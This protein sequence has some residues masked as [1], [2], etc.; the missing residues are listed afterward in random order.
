M[1]TPQEG[2]ELARN[3]RSPSAALS[4]QDVFASEQHFIANRRRAAGFREHDMPGEKDAQ[5][6]PD[7]SNRCQHTT[8]GLALSGGGIRSA[9]IGLG[10]IQVL[11]KY[12]LFRYV[13]YLSAISGGSYTGALI[14]SS[15]YRATGDTAGRRV[16]GDT[17][18]DVDLIDQTIQPAR[19]R[20]LMNDGRYLM[21]PLEWANR[22]LSGWLSL[23]LVAGSALLAI[24]ALV[25]FLWRSMDFYTV[26]HYLSELGLASDMSSALV[27][28]CV[29]FGLWIIGWGFSYFRD[30]ASARGRW[31]KKILVAIILCA[32][33]TVAGLIGNGDIEFSSG[34]QGTASFLK[35]PLIVSI[36]GGLIPTLFR[37]QLF[38]S[39]L[40]ESSFIEKLIYRYT[41]LAVVLG[42]PMLLIGYFARE[43]VSGFSASRDG[44]LLWG[45]VKDFPALYS[46]FEQPAV[47]KAIAVPDVTSLLDEIRLL[48]LAQSEI[49]ARIRG[50]NR[51]RSPPRPPAVFTSIGGDDVED[52]TEVLTTNGEPL[53]S[54]SPSVLPV[55]ATDGRVD[56]TE[57]TPYEPAVTNPAT[58]FDWI[59]WNYN[60][61]IHRGGVL[62]GHLFGR[63]SDDPLALAILAQKRLEDRESKLLKVFNEYFLVDRRFPSEVLQK[64][65]VD[66][67]NLSQPPGST[68][69]DERK[70]YIERTV[71][72]K[73]SNLSADEVLEFNRT[74]LEAA[75]PELIRTRSDIRRTV[76]IHP[77]Q[78]HRFLM[79][80]L[81]AG[82]FVVSAYIINPNTT[83]IQRYYQERLAGAYLGGSDEAHNMRL[84]DLAPRLG[85]GPLL[86]L[87]G[88]ANYRF[89]PANKDKN[90]DPVSRQQPIESTDRIGRFEFSPLFCGSKDLDYALTDVY[91]NGS[92][93]LADAVAI[94][95]AALNPL[96]FERWE[97]L[98][99]VGLLNLRL[100]QWMPNP[101]GGAISLKPTF[102]ALMR[103]IFCL[104][105]RR[106]TAVTER[107]HVLLTD[108]GH[109]DNTGLQALLERRCKV[110]IVCDG[111][112]DANYEF[113]SFATVV[114][115]M[116]GQEGITFHEIGTSKELDL[117]RCSA[118]FKNK[119]AHFFCCEVKYPLRA[120]STSCTGLL[121]YFKSSL[122]SDEPPFVWHHAA[123]NETFPHDST[124][125][126]SFSPAQFCA[127]LG[128]GQ[129][130]VESTVEG[131]RHA[132]KDV[133]ASREFTLR[134][135]AEL[136]LSHVE[137]TRRKQFLDRLLATEPVGVTAYESAASRFNETIRTR[138][139]EKLPDAMAQ[140][141]ECLAARVDL[142]PYGVI[143][144]LLAGAV[145]V[146]DD[147]PHP[148]AERALQEAAIQ[149][150]KVLAG[151]C[152]SDDKSRTAQKMAC[153]IRAR[154]QQPGQYRS[155]RPILREA[156]DGYTDNLI[157]HLIRD[158][159]IAQDG[160]IVEVMGELGERLVKS[161]VKKS[162]QL[163]RILSEKRFSS[164]TE[165]RDCADRL[166]ALLDDDGAPNERR[167]PKP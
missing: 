62:L 92:L 126:Q 57:M 55:P 146:L 120:A 116:K 99:I 107:R 109:F 154:F 139:W 111:T 145:I 65:K 25:A 163:R 151:A 1:A 6:P 39:G 41:A 24:S 153:E 161:R 101:G 79:F 48:R 96:Y 135:F 67:L 150:S 83:S 59:S 98:V 11:R 47:E 130:F 136:F 95:G 165:I 152:E 141:R 81:F 54:N 82:I 76:V 31:A 61:I 115:R 108:G 110:V 49:Q 74:F 5:S 71:A 7:Q 18:L 160:F 28:L 164:V 124:V 63:D 8:V 75:H 142:P 9:S 68:F 70:A 147:D 137:E 144:D 125:N 36:F 38:R 149:F 94:S 51:W 12:G 85:S 158:G 118:Q 77:D 15:Y 89:R 72:N 84:T 90:P 43:D 93:R 58:L 30:G 16:D 3:C 100:G 69:T 53:L 127:Y 2:E 129:H 86:L 33:A 133:G 105:Q 102:A 122:S 45:D 14:A 162:S 87:G 35:I 119:E 112:Q 88:A 166:F 131:Q 10:F 4:F 44:R 80:L 56:A 143:L 157:E 34:V 148:N 66:K 140:L 113:D 97:M 22:F 42:I 106:V 156:G 132:V 91:Y 32:I 73:L 29:L 155:V 134:D 13:D 78:L 37:K 103:D 50:S 121:V 114:G 17:Q 23:L 117:G 138:Q 104:K 167:Q 128:L 19:V 26:R 159:D 52:P 123:K 27:P 60:S 64:L 20:A 40:V 46:W 21:R